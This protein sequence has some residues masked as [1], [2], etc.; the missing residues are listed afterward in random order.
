[1][2]YLTN[3]IILICLIVRLGLIR[4]HKS[5]KIYKD[6]FEDSYLLHTAEFYT[7]ES[8]N[9]LDTLGI[10]LYIQK[11]LAS[12]HEE[13]IRSKKYLDSSSFEL[14]CVILSTNSKF[15]QVM[16][17]CERALIHHH[18]ARLYSEFSAM[19]K[20]DKREDLK[21]I[22]RLFLRVEGGINP[23]LETLEKYIVNIGMESIKALQEGGF[24]G[25]EAK[26]MT[27]V[28]IKKSLDSI[29]EGPKLEE[30]TS[31]I[32]TQT[33]LKTYNQFHELVK[34]TFDS[35]PGFVSAL[36]KVDLHLSYD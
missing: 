10:S 31:E 12:L 32:Y 35:H 2:V 24:L 7:R 17:S 26:N 1:M 9:D 4:Q 13:E 20:D 22:Y 33:L 36:D 19:L 3:Y 15:I 28:P 25:E 5:L 30:S 11:A 27:N 16:A 6:D 18:N 34:T 23:L 14:V 8:A 21:N 29:P